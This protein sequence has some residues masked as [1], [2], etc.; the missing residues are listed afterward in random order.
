M[1]GLHHAGGI[2]SGIVVG[3]ITLAIVA[4]V[5]S[6][7]ANTSSVIGAFGT[8]LGGTIAAAVSPITGSNAGASALGNFGS[9]GGGNSGGGGLGGLGNIFGGSGGGFNPSSLLGLASFGSALA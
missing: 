2:V 6:Q 9:F 3:M 1:E 4:V 8:A 5:L 7:R